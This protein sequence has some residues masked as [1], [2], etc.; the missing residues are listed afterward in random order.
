MNAKFA[1]IEV[2]VLK[3]FCLVHDRRMGRHIVMHKQYKVKKIFLQS[4]TS[5]AM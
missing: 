2:L 1:R 4:R 5:I 3:G